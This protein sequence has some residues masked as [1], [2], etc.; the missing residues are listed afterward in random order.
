MTMHKDRMNIKVNLIIAISCIAIF[1]HH[2]HSFE[3]TDKYKLRIHETNAFNH[4]RRRAMNSCNMNVETSSIKADNSANSN[5]E[6]SDKLQHFI[7]TSNKQFGQYKGQSN[8]EYRNA[9]TNKVIK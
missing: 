3:L 9:V 8:V 2:L 7:K 1:R 5:T 4:F 6:F